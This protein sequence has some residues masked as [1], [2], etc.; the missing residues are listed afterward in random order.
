MVMF[1]RWSRSLGY[2]LELVDCWHTGN[3]DT[4]FS[5]RTDRIIA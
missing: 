2:V 1:N 5:R 4:Q 3:V